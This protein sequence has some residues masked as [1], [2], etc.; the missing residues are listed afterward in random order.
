MQSVSPSVNATDDRA[1]AS[2]H[3]SQPTT[4]R[5]TPP[6]PLSKR[7]R[8]GWVAEA[9]VIATV[10]FLYETARN[11][12]TGSAAQALRNAKALTSIEKALGI[13]QERAF[14][15]FFLDMPFLVA[16]WNFYYDTAHF[17]VP[18][19]VAVYLYVKAPARYV[20]M[21][22]TF[23]FLLLGFG[24]L[25][26]YLLPITAP[27]WMPE[28]YGFVDTQV[29]YYNIGP[30][31]KLAYGADGE[32]KPH[33]ISATGNP[34]GGL[35]SHHVSWSVFCALALWPVVRRR[36]VKGLLVAHVLLTIGA[37]TVTG[38]HRFIDIAGSILEVTIAYSLAIGLERVLAWRRARRRESDPDLEPEFALA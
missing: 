33:V 35:P 10:G 20:R 27:K 5:D 8:F 28:S 14:Q 1:G 11:L 31:V 29:E 23:F 17:L 24:L 22:N 16:L 2:P 26:W 3:G 32:P 21:R 25:G 4:P 12:V 15:H 30:Q 6:G 18:I 38:N 36:W 13:Y 7:W 37:I 19:A 9:L 34:Y